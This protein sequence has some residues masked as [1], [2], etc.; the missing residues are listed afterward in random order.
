M[1]M[2]VPPFFIIK[3][4]ER[5]DKKNKNWPA[6]FAGLAA[7]VERETGSPRLGIND[8]KLL[9]LNWGETR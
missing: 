5:A 2:L 3:K 9:E 7:A 8:N 1:Y 4:I 6:N